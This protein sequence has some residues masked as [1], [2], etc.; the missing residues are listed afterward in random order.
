ML[1][2]KRGIWQHAFDTY[3]TNAHEFRQLDYFA[4]EG[5]LFQGRWTDGKF[6]MPKSSARH[7]KRSCICTLRHIR[8]LREVQFVWMKYVTRQRR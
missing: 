1:P 8:A 4:G 6:Q 7:M 3:S 2:S 5:R